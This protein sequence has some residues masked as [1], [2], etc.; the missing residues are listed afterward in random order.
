MSAA[1]A[2]GAAAFRCWR[3][4]A[5]PHRQTIGGL[6]V[7]A[8]ATRLRF[9]RVVLAAPDGAPIHLDR[10]ALGGR[11][12]DASAPTVL[13]IHGLE[14]SARAGYACALYRR[15][16]RLG[17][18]AVGFNFNTCGVD[19]V[20]PARRLY[21]LGQTEDVAAALAWLRAAHPA[22]AIG[23]V[24]V[25]L[26]GN[27]LL[28]L[29]GEAGEGA[30]VQAAVAISV[31]YDPLACA[32]HL[33]RPKNLVYNRFF[34]RGL[35]AKARARRRLL[36]DRVD[37]DA[38]ARARTIRQFDD[39]LTAPLHGFAGAT[40]YYTRSA[41]APA[42]TA[43]RCPTLL[44]HAEDDPFLPDG[45]IPRRAAAANPAITAAVTRGGG[46]VGFIGRGRQL[47]AE[48]TAASWLADRLLAAG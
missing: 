45:G 24:G 14:G 40:D 42:L 9:E 38:V 2:A 43:I 20:A 4:L 18:R 47:W 16:A 19:H 35:Q 15:L 11:R 6:A 37:L 1:G 33:E 8:P 25:S 22:A 34:L 7:R 31:P 30:D 32:D 3:P 13:V 23:A 48:D 28:K 17:V 21:H 27:V 12:L 29:L 36:A 26:G 46:H 41:S 44:I 5:G 10:P 39:R